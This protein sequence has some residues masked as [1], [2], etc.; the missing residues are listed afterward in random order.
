MVVVNAL[1][2]LAALPT[3]AEWCPSPSLVSSRQCGEDD[4]MNVA[5]MV[6]HRCI[7]TPPGS[8]RL[9]PNEVCPAKLCGNGSAFIEPI[10]PTALL[11]QTDYRPAR[12]NE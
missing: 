1:L 8:H 10:V 12:A 5:V 11:L 6:N 9:R 4:D 3:T 7:S 2:V